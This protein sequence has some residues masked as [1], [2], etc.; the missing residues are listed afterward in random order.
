MG[1][2]CG[3][4]A[5]SAAEL[6]PLTHRVDPSAAEFDRTFEDIITRVGNGEFQKVVPVVHEDLRFAANLGPRMFARAWAK[7]PANQWSYGFSLVD[8]GLAGVTPEI[9]FRVRDD[10]LTT[11]AL[12]GTGPAEGPALLD[13]P[14]ERREHELVIEHVRGELAR[15]GTPAIGQTVERTYGSLKHLFTPIELHLERPPNFMELVTALHPTAALGGYPRRPA[16]EWLERQPFH[17][18]RR[19]F[20]APFGFKDK[21]QAT[22]VV[23]IRGV[24]WRGRDLMVAAG[25]G[26]VDGSRVEREWRELELK[27]SAIYRNLGLTP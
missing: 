22:C 23:A 4:P 15:F 7:P 13:D 9:L 26:V 18:A 1:E 3:P 8:E 20:G 16:I 25:C 14:K 10:R 17:R 24:Q 6:P 5:W 2:E 19:R 21:D 12:A 11:M 27:R